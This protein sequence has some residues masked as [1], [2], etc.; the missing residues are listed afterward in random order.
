MTRPNGKVA[1]VT[2]AAVGIG[3]AVERTQDA[4]TGT[5]TVTE[6]AYD[7]RTHQARRSASAGD[8]RLPRDMRRFFWDCAFA[9]L[10]WETDRDFVIG[11]LMER[12]DWRA[13]QWLR[14]MAGDA[15][16][17]RW[18]EARRGRG[19]NPRRLRYWELVLDLPHRRV[20]AW[21]EAQ[22]I[23]PWAGRLGA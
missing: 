10:R 2:G 23:L 7:N 5:S 12:G 9:R 19:M 6:P 3:R 21:I 1:I 18:L 4:V 22:R 16:L 15:E 11:R 17:R 8:T 13:T 20:S 14:R